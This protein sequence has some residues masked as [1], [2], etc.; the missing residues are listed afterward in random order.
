[1]P[2]KGNQDIQEFGS[3]DETGPKDPERT[4]KKCKADTFEHK[5]FHKMRPFMEK[6]YGEKFQQFDVRYYFKWWFSQVLIYTVKI[7]ITP[8]EYIHVK[9]MRPPPTD[10]EDRFKFYMVAFDGQCMHEDQLNFHKLPIIKRT[11]NMFVQFKETDLFKFP[12]FIHPAMGGFNKF[13]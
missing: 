9:I 12:Q 6:K 10:N 7:R 5:L 11:S 3:F 2:E 1:M 4:R 13:I 8:I